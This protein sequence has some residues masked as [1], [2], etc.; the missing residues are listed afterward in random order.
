VTAQHFLFVLLLSLLLLSLFARVVFFSDARDER[1]DK[2]NPAATK[3]GG[4]KAESIC[5]LAV[6]FYKS[7]EE[8]AVGYTHTTLIITQ[9][10]FFII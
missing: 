4:R 5:R 7:K 9:E 2:K 1:G 6:C 3:K 8:S 10:C